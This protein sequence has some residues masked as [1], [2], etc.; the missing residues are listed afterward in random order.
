MSRTRDEVIYLRL[1]K[2][3]KEEIIK[4]MQSIRMTNL[5]DFVRK[6]LLMG[7]AIRV[8]TNGLNNLAYEVNKVGNNINQITRL[9]NQRG[10]VTLNDIDELNKNL[11]YINSFIENFYKKINKTMR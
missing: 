4:K 8:D 7:T 1:T 10:N 2:E 5:N 9:A 11:S 6:I 3:E